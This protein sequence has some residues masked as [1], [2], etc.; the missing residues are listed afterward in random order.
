ML[1]QAAV[2]RKFS[3][4]GWRC[5]TRQR[6]A[7]LCMWLL[8]HAVQVKH[9]HLSA[10]AL[11]LADLGS[12]L[13]NL[14]SLDSL[15]ITDMGFPQAY[16]IGRALVQSHA[17]IT[18]FSC[19]GCCEP[20]WLLPS[21]HLLVLTPLDLDSPYW[22]FG[23]LL[24]RIQHQAP[25]L[26]K[27]QVVLTGKDPFSGVD[28]DDGF[29]TSA[30]TQIL[31]MAMKYRLDALQEL[32]ISQELQLKEWVE[33]YADPCRSS[34]N[35]FV[36]NLM[37]MLHARAC[38]SMDALRLRPAVLPGLVHVHFRASRQLTWDEF[39][40]VCD[41]DSSSDSSKGALQ[42]LQCFCT[43][44]SLHPDGVNMQIIAE[45]G[46]PCHSLALRFT[47]LNSKQVY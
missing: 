22:D 46:S 30:A 12:F 10:L 9:L 44:F 36:C 32:S 33:H 23:E 28:A 38:D 13:G 16:V 3:W 35:S 25:Q 14:P 27:L 2:M 21:T 42:W 19:S 37:P 20:G 6:C 43:T 24:G 26:R 17:P 39:D 29:E 7:A 15:C 40:D 41:S 11:D 8:Q 31:E 45:E 34:G 18:S 1:A 5:Y 47:S 4:R